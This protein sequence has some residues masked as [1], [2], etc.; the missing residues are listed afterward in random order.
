[1][2]MRSLFPTLGK[3]KASQ[4]VSFDHEKAQFDLAQSDLVF[5]RGIFFSGNRG[6]I[7]SLMGTR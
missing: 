6:G 4:S 5:G 7:T 2:V 1:M 3:D